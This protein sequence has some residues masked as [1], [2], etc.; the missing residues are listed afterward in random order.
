MEK[1][2]V[3]EKSQVHI[4]KPIRLIPLGCSYSSSS[5]SD[6]EDKIGENDEICKKFQ[7]FDELLNGCDN[8]ISNEYLEE[9]MLKEVY[10]EY[11]QLI[12]K[13]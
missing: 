5:Q 4:P 3:V 7:L 2:E 6:F 1:D 8:N 9:N 10:K 11:F 13:I 12:Y